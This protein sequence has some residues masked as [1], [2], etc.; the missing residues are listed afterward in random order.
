MLSTET[1]K[2]Y[3]ALIQWFTHNFYDVTTDMLYAK[4][5]L[6]PHQYLQDNF[7]HSVNTKSYYHED[8]LIDILD[9][10]IHSDI[11]EENATLEE[12]DYE[13]ADDTVN[14]TQEMCQNVMLATID[15]LQKL[16]SNHYFIVNKSV[17]LALQQFAEQKQVEL[18]EVLQPFL[19]DGEENDDIFIAAIPEVLIDKM[20]NLPNDKDLAFHEVLIQLD[21]ILFDVNYAGTVQEED[22]P[23]YQYFHEH[24]AQLAAK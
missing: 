21:T 11:V 14:Y 18:G 8:D 5:Q 24:I 13:T 23:F 12:L 19:G 4:F 15:Q 22:M 17:G 1:L 3:H 9:Y 10:L 16:G 6:L 20:Y 2:N 7:L